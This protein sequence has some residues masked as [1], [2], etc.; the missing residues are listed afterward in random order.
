MAIGLVMSGNTALGTWKIVFESQT[1]RPRVN[2]V[3]IAAGAYPLPEADEGDVIEVIAAS[4]DVI[5]D[6]IQTG[7]LF[8]AP[9]AITT[10]FT[11]PPYTKFT[12][13]NVG[14]NNWSI[15]KQFESRVLFENT[16]SGV[17]GSEVDY[18]SD[19][20]VVNQTV[21]GQALTSPPTSN[22]ASYRL[23]IINVGTE[24]FTFEGFTVAASSA[25][26]VVYE[27]TAWF[28]L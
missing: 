27:G 10:P 2:Y 25:I 14:D 3:M 26:Q 6:N 17:I 18:L 1:L 8:S 7:F 4:P 20:F 28:K 19:I 21:A 12:I 15:V 24:A 22:F 23:A 9:G 11:L 16:L 5:I 13:F